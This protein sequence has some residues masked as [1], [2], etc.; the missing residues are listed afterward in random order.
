[1]ADWPKAIVESLGENA[2]VGMQMWAKGDDVPS[3][4]ALAIGNDGNYFVVTGTVTI[5]SIATKQ[6]GTVIYLRFS[7]ILTLTHNASI[8]LQGATNMTTAVGDIVG[9]ISDGAGVW[10][11]LFRRPATAAYVIAQDAAHGVLFQ[12]SIGRKL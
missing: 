11:E 4:A 10:R 6:G 8:I 3:A 5:T 2:F 1:M 9:L 12:R 7:G